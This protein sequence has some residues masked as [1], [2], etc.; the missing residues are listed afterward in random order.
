V[1]NTITV[2]IKK[3]VEG[4]LFASGF[5]RA[6]T[7]HGQKPARD[8]TAPRKNAEWYRS[9]AAVEGGAAGFAGIVGSVA[10]FPAL[11]AIKIKFLF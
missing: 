4:V 9:T 7:Y 2:I 11:L 5:A 6:C 1:H 10:D 8:R 3:M